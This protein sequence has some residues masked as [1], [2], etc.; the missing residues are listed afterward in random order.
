MG[1]PK[2]FISPEEEKEQERLFNEAKN[3]SATINL[4][5]GVI[6]NKGYYYSEVLDGFD[7]NIDNVASRIRAFQEDVHA[8][9]KKFDPE[10][11]KIK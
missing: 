6:Q 8:F 4:L 11:K 3:I 2:E 10:Y 9:H 5:G 7:E 1:Q